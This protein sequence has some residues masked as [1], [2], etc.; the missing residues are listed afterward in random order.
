M[1]PNIAPVSAKLSTI[2]FIALFWVDVNEISGD[3]NIDLTRVDF[4]GKN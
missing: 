1:H 3:V 2:D 4:T